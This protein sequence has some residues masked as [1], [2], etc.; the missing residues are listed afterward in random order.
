VSN[1]EEYYASLREEMEKSL[2]KTTLSEQLVED[3]RE[4]ISLLPDELEMKK[5]DLFKK[6]SI[7]V[8]I[9]PCALMLITTPAIKILYKAFIGRE[10]K[11]VSMI[12]NPI[13]KSVDPLVCEGCGTSINSVYSCKALHLLCF[14]CGRRCPVCN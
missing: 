8:K 2:Q 14:D 6:Y 3:R 1:L 4:K 5:E 7:R 11:N 9:H 13:T 12:Y 10:S